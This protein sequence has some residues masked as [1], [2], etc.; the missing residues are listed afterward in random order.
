MLPGVPNKANNNSFYSFCPDSFWDRFRRFLIMDVPLRAW[1]SRQMRRC[2]IRQFLLTVVLS[3]VLAIQGLLLAVSGGLAA[4][5]TA[6]GGI[7]AICSAAASTNDDAPNPSGQSGYHD[8]LSACVANQ[9]S[10][11][12]PAN[13]VLPTHPM[14]DGGGSVLQQTTLP[15]YSQTNGFLARA[16]PMLT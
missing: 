14:L 4:A 2:P 6:G 12:P 11:E 7:G 16:P 9:V 5:G 8:C 10:G 1:H 15:V 13:T 3:H